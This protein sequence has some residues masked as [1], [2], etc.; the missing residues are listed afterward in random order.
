MSSKQESRSPQAPITKDTR[1]DTLSDIDPKAV[2]ALNEIGIQTVGQL[3]RSSHHD[4]GTIIHQA[5]PGR[6]ISASKSVHAINQ[7]IGLP[8]TRSSPLSSRRPLVPSIST[9]TQQSA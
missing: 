5:M 6:S 9:S 2:K 8:L 3:K 1:L 4:F 7:Y